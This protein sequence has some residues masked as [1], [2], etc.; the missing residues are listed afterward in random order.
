MTQ[1]ISK[2]RGVCNVCAVNKDEADQGASGGGGWGQDD[3]RGKQAGGKEEDEEEDAT[4]FHWCEYQVTLQSGL[5][6]SG[7][8]ALACSHEPCAAAA[9]G[10]NRWNACVFELLIHSS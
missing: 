4:L 3:V 6:K 1:R 10:P 2:L 7:T 9:Q 5:K 8:A